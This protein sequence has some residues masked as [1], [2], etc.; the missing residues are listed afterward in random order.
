VQTYNSLLLVKDFAK[1][2]ALVTNTDFMTT[3][4][5]PILLCENLIE[6]PVNPFTQKPL[7]ADK[8]DGVVITTSFYPD[9]GKYGYNIYPFEWLFVK[10]N[11]F[12]KD[13]WSKY[14]IQK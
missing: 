10:D 7:E 3:A 12:D 2:G 8:K 6:N 9:P 14:A 1:T 13:N 4:D 5:V 11:I